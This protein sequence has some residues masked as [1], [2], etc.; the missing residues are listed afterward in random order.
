MYNDGKHKTIYHN[1]QAYT[2]KHD[3]I[4]KGISFYYMINDNTLLVM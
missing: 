2:K 4:Q 3:T 1:R